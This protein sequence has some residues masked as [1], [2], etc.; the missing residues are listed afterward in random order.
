MRWVQLCGSLNILRPCLSVDCN[1]TDLFQ[2]CDL[3]WVFQICLHI[4]CSTF[5]ASSFRIWNSSNGIPS[6]PLALFVMMLSKATWLRIPGCLALCEWS[7]I[8]GCLGHEDLFCVVLLCILATYSLISSASVGSIPHLSFLVPIFAWNSPLVSLIF[9]KRS[10]VLPILLFFSISLH[11]E[12]RKDF[13][14][15]FAILW[16]SAFR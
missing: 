13:L 10:L 8:H 2:S 4:E 1:E 7:H 5:T 12:V 3:C 9:L 6:P 14:S 16:N 11:W 15:L